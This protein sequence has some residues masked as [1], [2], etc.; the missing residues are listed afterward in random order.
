ME[1]L[2]DLGAVTPDGRPTPDGRRMASLPLH[3]RLAK[4]ALVGDKTGYGEDAL[5]LVCI[6]SEGPLGSEGFPTPG[7]GELSLWQQ[8]N[9]VKNEILRGRHD[10]TENFFSA[11]LSRPRL[12]QIVRL[13][14]SL[15]RLFQTRPSTNETFDEK[16]MGRL[17]LAGFP[18]RVGKLRPTPKDARPTSKDGLSY[19]LVTGGGGS[20]MPHSSAKGCQWLLAIEAEESTTKHADQAVLIR[21]A[22][23]IDVSDLE[24]LDSPR[25]LCRKEAVWSEEAQRVDLMDRRLYGPLLIEESRLSITD[26]DRLIVQDLLLQKLKDHWPKPFPDDT[27][28][29]TYHTR[30]AILSDKTS[31]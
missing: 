29:T 11:T 25:L 14:Q 23:P 13:F 18:D 7:Q 1:L 17:L 8:L 20:L 2:K 4:I 5:L 26:N 12:G 15:K 31:A 24:S 28:L 3:P 22:L 9:L 10:K 19:N 16:H 30:V 21:T 6:L 27:D